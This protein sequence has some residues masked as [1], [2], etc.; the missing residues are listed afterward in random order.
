MASNIDERRHLVIARINGLFGVRGELKVFSYS[1][2]RQQIFSYN[3]WLI[4][5]GSSWI[6]RKVVA[7][8]SRGR[9]LTVL[10]EG[11]ENREQARR[12][13]GVDIAIYRD[14]LPPLPD[15]EFYWCDLIGL[16]VINQAGVALGKVIEVQETGAND[17]L[18]VQQG[19]QNILIP[20][21]IG[22]VVQEVD[23]EQG[24]MQVDWDPEYL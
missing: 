15:G 6:E 13:M 19:Q 7:G 23:M 20:F 10:L 18:V 2:P 4:K 12:L 14:Q 17:V 16:D 9:G 24:H 5:L 21:V 11:I 3:P 22:A 8:K 1:R